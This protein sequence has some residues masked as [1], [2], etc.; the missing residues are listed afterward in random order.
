MPLLRTVVPS[1]LCGLLFTS[2]VEHRYSDLGPEKQALYSGTQRGHHELSDVFFVRVSRG[3]GMRFYH[4]NPESDRKTLI[5]TIRAPRYDSSDYGSRGGAFAI[6]RDGKTLL[7]FHNPGASRDSP[8][9]VEGLYQ[10][11]H[12]IGDALIYDDCLRQSGDVP[13]N[14]VTFTRPRG[15]IQAILYNR[16]TEC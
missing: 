16:T 7:Y 5:G 15:S 9:K 10:F 4:Y 12:G 2:C 14:T 1:V 11:T 6:S 3:G 8:A 13:E